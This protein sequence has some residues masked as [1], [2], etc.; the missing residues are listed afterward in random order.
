[1]TTWH[2]SGSGNA[3][4]I[5]DCRQHP[6][7]LSPQVIGSLCERRVL[8]LP[9]AEGVLALREVQGSSLTADFYNPDGSTGPMCGN[10][11]RTL[12]AWMVNSGLEQPSAQLTL[13]VSGVRYPARCPL[14]NQAEIVFPAPSATNKYPAGTLDGVPY[15][16]W[17]VDVGS[18][19][20]VVFDVG[21]SFDPRVLR[22]H[23][24]FPRGV[25]VNMARITSP[26][27]ITLTTFER[28]VERV[29]GACGTGAISTAVVALL[30][31]SATSPITITPPSS[32]QLIVAQTSHPAG[33][34][35][36]SL[37]G[38]TT[39]DHSPV[40]FSFDSQ[41]YQV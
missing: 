11:G 25:N 22:H 19:H 29:T 35:G 18:D 2:Y 26:S 4:V 7:K 41:S 20:A 27:T 40:D 33:G 34:I 10:G 13:N 12:A 24:A 28:G 32:Q 5:I 36:F 3:M 30:N 14:P 1:M 6:A 21:E 15:D 16:V 31:G 38:P 39:I 17:Y 37:C 23:A 8:D 9:P